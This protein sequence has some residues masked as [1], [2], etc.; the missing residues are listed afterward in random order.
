MG[1]AFDPPTQVTINSFIVD[2]SFT[3]ASVDRDCLIIE[4]F[5]KIVNESEEIKALSQQVADSSS[6][7][8][9]KQVP[10]IILLV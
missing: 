5:K 6:R 1:D 10:I 7:Q 4:E 2:Y 9:L 8:T 3:P